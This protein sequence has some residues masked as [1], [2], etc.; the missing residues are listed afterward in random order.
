MELLCIQSQEHPQLPLAE[1]MQGPEICDNDA[2]IYVSLKVAGSAYSVDRVVTVRGDISRNCPLPAALPEGI[3]GKKLVAEIS[4][5]ALT[6]PK[7][8]DNTSAVRCAAPAGVLNNSGKLWCALRDSS[9]KRKAQAVML[10]V[11]RDGKYHVK[12][13]ASTI[14]TRGSH[15]L[16]GKIKVDLAGYNA[17]LK[18]DQGYEIKVSV[19][20]EKNGNVLIDRIF[21]SEK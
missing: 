21:I 17:M 4:Q 12:T 18:P 8:L 10:A 2:A 5:I 16:L 14:F 6:S 20:A 7:V 9:G 1:F 11:P 19:K 3:D 13:L 15:L